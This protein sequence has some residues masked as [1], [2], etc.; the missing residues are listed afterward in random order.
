VTESTTIPR[1]VALW[2]AKVGSRSRQLAFALVCAAVVLTAHLGRIGTVPAR[3]GAGAGFLLVCVVL[4][5]LRARARRVLLTPEGVIRR[6]VMPTDRELGQ[7]ALRAQALSQRADGDEGVG[8]AELA[9]LHLVRVLS[10]ISLDAIG[11]TAARAAQKRAWVALVLLTAAGAGVLFEPARVLEGLNVLAARR[12]QAPLPLSWLSMVQVSVQPPAYL[13]AAEQRIFPAIKNALPAGSVVTVR[14]TPERPGR[15]V[16][17]TDGKREVPFVDDGSGNLVAHW[18]LK[19]NALLRVAARFGDVLVIEREPL[20]FEAVPDEAPRIQ[21]E[22]APRSVELKD[23]SRLELRFMASD[24]HGLRQIDLVLRSG[25]REE[26]RVLMRLD[27]Q[28]R[29]ERGAHALDPRDAFLRRM[30]LPVVA[31]IEARDNDA[32]A[33]SKWGKSEALTILPPAVGEPEALRLAALEGARDKIVDLLEHQVGTVRARTDN[34]SP[35]LLRERKTQEGV[36]HKA[37]LESLKAVVAGT[38]AGVRVSGGLSAFVLG[39]AQALEKRS[40]TPQRRTEDV[41]LASD[42]GIRALATRDAQQVSKR[43]GDVAEE[44]AEGAKVARDT[45]QRGQGMRRSDLALGVLERGARNLTLLGALGADVGGVA[46]GEIRRIR[47]ARAAENFL[48]AELAA[49][50]LA[51]RLRRPTPSFSS[52]GGGSV[53]SGQGA[54]GPGEASEADRQFDQLMRELGQLAA[55]HAEEIRRVEQTLAEAE[56]GS[57]SEELKREAA[58]RARKLRDRLD[59][60]P[61]TWAQEGSAR[62]AAALGREHMAAMAHDLERLALKDAVESGRNADTKLDESRRLS[63]DDGAANWLDSQGLEG[64]SQELREQLDWAEKTLQK[65]KQQAQGRAAK[66]L[67]RAGEREQELGKRAGNL[68]GRGAQGEASLPDELSDALERAENAMQEASR[69]LAEGRG[70]EGLELEREAQR[71]LERSSSGRTDEGDD[72]GREPSSGQHE[73]NGRDVST[74]GS[75][76]SVDKARRAEQ[77]RKRVLDGLSLQRRGRLGPAVERYAEGLLE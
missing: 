11:R 35:E 5:V 68:A 39:Q 70:E 42:S 12:G 54:P 18:T 60:L 65:L 61:N 3:A 40:A 44:V 38:Y 77:F 14:G 36:L 31:T 7:R 37:A 24:D 74:T 32:T 20:E 47:R 8:S 22:E 19:E 2:H 64:A 23:L 52:A 25:A 1:L 67:S 53:E 59:S 71:L 51:L 33:S 41:L 29:V 45:E 27:G 62:A 66:E 43:L 16:V 49:R 57:D 28:S 21:L 17:L 58:E 72:E 6:V 75:V 4:L 76:P 50:H 73:G 13:R 55:E 26:R 34:A 46:L 63:K 30:F 56:Q 15:R 10:R 9:R 69:E 48:E